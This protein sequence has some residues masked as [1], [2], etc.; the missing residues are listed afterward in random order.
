M[1]YT[2]FFGKRISLFTLGTAQLNQKYGISNSSKIPDIESVNKILDTCVQ[3]GINSFDTAPMYADSEILLGNYF[4]E[5]DHSEII[6]TKIPKIDISQ[7]NFDDIYNVLHTQIMNSLQRLQL[8]SL[9]VCLLHDTSNMTSNDGL[10]IDCLEKLKEEKLIQKIGVSTY[11]PEDVEYFLAID[12]FDIIQ[13]PLNIFDTRLIQKKLIE[14]LYLKN[15][16]IFARS[17]FL[18]GLLLMDSSKLSPKLEKTSLLLETLSNLSQE[19]DMAINELAFNFVRSVKGISSIVIG[20]D[21]ISQLQQNLSLLETEPLSSKIQ[22]QILNT[23]SDIEEEIIN[24][25][26]WSNN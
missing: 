14:K 11:T 15:T 22:N 10:I 3:N 12:K 25:S 19:Y 6:T 26:L 2:D 20:C 23:F 5:C 17:I 9:P 8:E 4:Q 16:V 21:N 13:L 7:N 1:E 18:Q 24:P